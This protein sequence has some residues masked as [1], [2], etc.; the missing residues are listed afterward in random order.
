MHEKGDVGGEF[1]VFRIFFED[2]EN[3]LM[4]VVFNSTSRGIGSLNIDSTGHM[5]SV[6]L[7][8]VSNNFSLAFAETPTL[9]FTLVIWASQKA[10]QLQLQPPI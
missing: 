9:I 6:L 5:A 2:L 4:V 8:A 7:H 3:Y 10:F 1:F